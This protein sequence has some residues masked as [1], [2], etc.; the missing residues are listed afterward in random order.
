MM[1]QQSTRCAPSAQPFGA[2]TPTVSRAIAPTLKTPKGSLRVCNASFRQSK[3]IPSL[4]A[5]ASVLNRGHRSQSSLRQRHQNGEGGQRSRLQCSAE[6]KELPIFPLNIVGIPDAKLALNIFEARYR[7]LFNTLLDGS[8]DVEDGLV[9]KECSWCGTKRFGLVFV[10]PQGQLAQVGCNL[11][12]EQHRQLGDGRMEVVQ[13]GVER[14]K[15]LRVIQEKPVLVCEVEVM[16]DE[17]AGVDDEEGRQLALDVRQL[18]KDVIR[19]GRSVQG[20]E[21]TRFPEEE[22]LNDL[23]PGE[24]SFW[25]A[26]LLGDV[27]EQQRLLEMTSARER[28]ERE[29]DVLATTLKYLSARSALKNALSDVEPEK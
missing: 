20:Q 17:D 21:M 10:G 16:E 24:V 8:D 22:E 25:V 23:S 9:Q 15:I 26:S 3:Q 28:L 7:V 1:L 18:L 5:R 13:R 4:A 14:F 12:I 29:Q 19:V 27:E 11:E 2:S 6:T